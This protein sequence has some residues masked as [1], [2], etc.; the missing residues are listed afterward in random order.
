MTKE[1]NTKTN[2][3]G[4]L[5]S[6]FI[7]FIISIINYP[8]MWKYVLPAIVVIILGGLLSFCE[9]K[10]LGWPTYVGSP[11]WNAEMKKEGLE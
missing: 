4:V 9:V 7:I 10:R 3:W 11:E 6:A 2:W 8:L 1:I 5:M